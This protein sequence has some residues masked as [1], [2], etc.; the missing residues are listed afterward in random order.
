MT[1]RRL[2]VLFALVLTFTPLR[3]A[4][5]LPEPTEL[6]GPLVITGGGKLP[7]D[8]RD[9]FFKLAGKDKAK[10]VVIPTAIATAGDAKT[11]ERVL[12][13]WQELKPESVVV[14]HTRDRKS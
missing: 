8:A 3:A 13:P 6:P 11:D 10:I 2:C 9:E 5:P 12:E 1:H 7:T 14:L 4:A